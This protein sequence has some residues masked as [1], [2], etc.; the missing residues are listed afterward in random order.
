ML[1]SLSFVGIISS[2]WI[3][4]PRGALPT[5]HL[6]STN[7][8]TRPTKRQN[9]YERKLK[10]NNPGARTITNVP[11]YICIKS[12]KTEQESASWQW[13]YLMD[14]DMFITNYELVS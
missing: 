3:V 10:K 14:S 7:N 2:P 12:H 8:L 13:C 6:A 9:T 5:N 1:F 11:I 4:F